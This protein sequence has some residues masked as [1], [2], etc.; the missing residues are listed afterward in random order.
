MTVAA[1]E[2][3][4][5]GYAKVNIAIK[6]LCPIRRKRVQLEAGVTNIISDAQ[7]AVANVASD[8]GTNAA[9]H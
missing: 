4:R 5:T 9:D 8:A 3:C 2:L 6:A 7:S 1:D